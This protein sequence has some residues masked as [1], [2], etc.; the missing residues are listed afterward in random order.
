MALI[1]VYL[2]H[3]G[4]KIMSTKI[5][6]LPDVKEKTGLSRSSIYSYIKG[7]M[8][9]RPVSLGARAVGFI[10]SEIN[11]WIEQRSKMRGNNHV[12]K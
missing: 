11:E 9:P 8:F 1:A 6:R 2:N 5:L 7:G 4:V 3:I 10:E 12:Q